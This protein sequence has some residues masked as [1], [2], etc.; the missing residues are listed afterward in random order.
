[1]SVASARDRALEFAECLYAVGPITVSR[2]FGG[3]GLLIDGVQ[4]AF[5][6]EGSLY[7][8]VDDD[9]RPRFQALGAAPFTYATRSRTVKVATYYEIP[10]AVAEDPDELGRWAAR[11]HRVAAA[12]KATARRRQHVRPSQ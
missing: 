10:D 3:A 5:V 7:L 2:F 1:M 6:M 9:S 4:F 11:A 12:A 8:R